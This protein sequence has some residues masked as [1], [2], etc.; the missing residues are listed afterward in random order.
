MIGPGQE[1]ASRGLPQI[2]ES[3][4][5]IPEILKHA[6]LLARITYMPVTMGMCTG[7]IIPGMFSRGTMVNGTTIS[8]TGP[9]VNNRSTDN[10]S[11]ANKVHSNTIISTAVAQDPAADPVA[12]HQDHR[13]LLGGE[14]VD[15]GRL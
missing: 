1:P 9:P 14:G 11:R 6:H 5:E 10:I 4:Q 15:G 12:G 2:T 7:G 13:Q 3:G 8:R